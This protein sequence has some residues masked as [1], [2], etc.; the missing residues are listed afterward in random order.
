[1][2]TVYGDI[3]DAAVALPDE[4]RA[5]LVEALIESLGPEKSLRF[6]EAWMA[7]V[8]R[9]WKDYESGVAPHSTWAEVKER[10]RGKARRDG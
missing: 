3:L 1:M 5:L 10:A 4:E 8:E 9:R 6:E 2:Q 7:V